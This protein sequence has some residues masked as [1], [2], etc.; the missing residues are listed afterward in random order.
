MRGKK[1]PDFLVLGTE[2]GLI[3]GAIFVLLRRAGI[4]WEQAPLFLGRLLVF[5][6]I[7]FG[8]AWI[9]GRI[10]ALCVRNW[11]KKKVNKL[12]WSI[13]GVA[14]IGAVAAAFGL[15]FG[16]PIIFWGGYATLLLPLGLGVASVWHWLPQ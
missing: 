2:L 1:H 15:F 8:L 12:S 11:P 7:L 9:V 14:S 3:G 16:A 13:T 6:P 10:I 5:L 4:G